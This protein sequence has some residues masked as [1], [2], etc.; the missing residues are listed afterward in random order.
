MTKLVLRVQEKVMVRQEVEMQWLPLAGKV[1]LGK[2]ARTHS[3]PTTIRPFFF[4][5]HLNK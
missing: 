5:F 2:W 1:E 4:I 3:A